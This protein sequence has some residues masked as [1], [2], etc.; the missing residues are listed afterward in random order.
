MNDG[1]LIY[2]ANDED[3]NLQ[4]QTPL[5]LEILL[6]SVMIVESSETSLLYNR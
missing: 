5:I 6:F 4:V 3:G 2:I 1:A